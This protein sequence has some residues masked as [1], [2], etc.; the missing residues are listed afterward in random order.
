MQ[1]VETRADHRLH[2]V[3]YIE[4]AQRA[5]EHHG[6]SLDAQD[7]LLQQRLTELL[8]EEWIPAGALV[9]QVVQPL[10]YLRHPQQCAQQRQRRRRLEWAKGDR[11][12]VTDAAAPLVL[13]PRPS[14]R[15]HEQRV[16]RHQIHDLAQHGARRVVGPVPVLQQQHRRP[17]PGTDGDERRDGFLHRH[18]ELLATKVLRQ[19]HLLGGNAQQVQIEGDELLQLG[20]ESAN[21][22]DDLAL[23]ILAHVGVGHVQR[24]TQHMNEGQIRRASTMRR[25]ASLENQRVLR[26]QSLAELVE[27]SALSHPRLADD[28]HELTRPLAGLC[29]QA[30]QHRELVTAPGEGSEPANPLRRLDARLKSG[31]TSDLERHE[32]MLA[33][34][35]RHRRARLCEDEPFHETAAL[36]ADPDLAGRRH[37]RQLRRDASRH[38]GDLER[39]I[40]SVP[41]M[42]H[43]RTCVDADAQA[44]HGT[45]ALLALRTHSARGVAQLEHGARGAQAVVL[46]CYRQPEHQHRGIRTGMRHRSTVPTREHVSLG[47]HLSC[48]ALHLGCSPPFHERG[49]IAELTDDDRRLASLAIGQRDVFVATNGAR[50]RGARGARHGGREMRDEVRRRRVAIGRALG[51]RRADHALQRRR[52]SR[53]GERLPPWLRVEDLSQHGHFRVAEEGAAASE[54][55]EQHDPQR[56]DVG[57]PIHPVVARLFG[58]HVCDRARPRAGPRERHVRQ[59]RDPEVEDLHDAVGGDHEIRRLHVAMHD[60]ARVRRREPLGRLTHER[61]RFSDRQRPTSNPRPH[62]LPFIERHGDEELPVVALADLVDRADVR[63]IERGDRL[64]LDA[65]ALACILVVAK[66]RRQE[67]EGDRAPER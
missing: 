9:Q 54:H 38:A 46:R 37:R 10:R 66:V 34:A 1:P 17:L 20:T 26:M 39:R 7:P 24:V 61:H 23:E 41:A 16:L 8:E 3:R 44:E 62:R 64:R 18:L 5:G 22:S 63:V 51:E 36:G 19:Q 28:A 31:F 60:P 49:V 4:L 12:M 52:H 29:E 58:T 27:Q 67:L 47:A 21:S 30:T 33:V 14:R 15:H 25:T 13:T 53:I 42:F 48:G 45:A 32:W 40:G 2:G 35:E 57:A 11:R 65:E 43:H 55:L 50:R 59:L 6:V 56:P